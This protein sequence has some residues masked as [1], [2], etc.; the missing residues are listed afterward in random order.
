MRSTSDLTK[1]EGL[2]LGWF[3]HFLEADGIEGLAKYLAH[4]QIKMVPGLTAGE[5]ILAH[6]HNPLGYDI[7]RAAMDLRTWPPIA[8]RIL[9]LQTEEA[10]RRASAETQT[11]RARRKRSQINGHA[12]GHPI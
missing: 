12:A 10:E 6:Y 4:C 5:A 1:N 2:V 3:A 9:E 8:T 7:D 11:R